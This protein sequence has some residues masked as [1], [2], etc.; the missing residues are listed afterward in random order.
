MLL[1]AAERGALDTEPGLAAEVERLLAAPE[2]KAAVRAF[3]TQMLELE[4]L[5]HLIKDPTLFPHYSADLGP[6]AREETLL[7][8]EQMRD[9]LVATF[10]TNPLFT[11]KLLE[12][13]IDNP[14]HATNEWVRL[15][16]RPLSVRGTTA[17]VGEWLPALVLPQ[18]AAASE[19]PASYRSLKL[20]LFAIWGD[21]DT[22]TPLDQARRLASL[23]PGAELTVLQGV[24]HI[25]QIEE[26]DAFHKALVAAIAKA[27]K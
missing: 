27:N 11:R 14:V 18:P 9:P 1:E 5:D 17:A 21:K 15:Y 13:F 25:P 19:Q 26:P 12:S 4:R 7:G 6:A 2:A 24:G 8:V 23:V 20:P 16:Q 3:F 10:L 22:I